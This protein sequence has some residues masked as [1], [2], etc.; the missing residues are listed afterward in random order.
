MTAALQKAVT[1]KVPVRISNIR[2]R[3]NGNFIY[4]DLSLRQA[5][6]P[7]ES[8]FP[9]LYLV[10]L[11]EVPVQI[12]SPDRDALLK[13]GP[14]K[15]DA[16]ENRRIVELEQELRAKEEYLQSTLE[17]ME[18]SSEELKSTNE[19]MQSVNEELQSSNEELETSKE[20][21]QS[22]NEELATVNSELQTKVS[23]LSRANNDMNNLLAGTG[24]ATI[25]V[26]Q[27][28]HIVRFTP[29]AI[30]LI[31]L[32]ATDIGRPVAHIVSNLA[33]YDRLAEDAQAVLNDLIPREAE[34]RTK[35]GSWFLMRIRPYRT[36]NNVIEGA[37]LTFTDIN[38][39]KQ[40]ND[41][42][43]ER[44]SQLNAILN[45]MFNAF[46][47][48]ESVSDNDGGF[49]GYRF[50]LMNDA[51]E[52]RTGIT[53]EQAY[54]KT[55]QEIYPGNETVWE[56]TLEQAAASSYPIRF[57]LNPAKVLR[58]RADEKI[59]TLGQLEPETQESGETLRIL[60]EL[61]VHRIELEM[62]NEDLRR[63]QENLEAA[64]ARYYDFY[65][66]APVGFCS[67]SEKGKI[68]E[69]NLVTA[70][71]LRSDRSMLVMKM[72]SGYILKEDQDIY[73]LLCKQLLESGEPQ[74]CELRMIKTDGAE[75]WVH[76]AAT[77]ALD[78]AGEPVSRFVLSDITDRK[79]AE[80]KIQASLAEK[81]VLLK[82]I[83]HRVKNNMQI[84][85]SLISLQADIQDDERVTRLFD[86]IRNR[87]K[88]MAMVHEKLYQT[89]DLVALDF[90]DYA[91]SLLRY[92]WDAHGAS[93]REISLKLEAAPVPFPVGTAVNCGLILNELAGNAL[94]HAFPG[95]RAGV[96][97]VT[98]A[99]DPE[100]KEVCLKVRDNGVGMPAEPDWRQSPSL[101]LR[102][103]QMLT[104]QIHGTVQTGPGPGTEFRICFSIKNSRF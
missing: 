103:V 15:T 81:D 65:N 97:T 67:I 13:K 70:E 27:Q 62:Q 91:G 74:A 23:D 7:A 28:L 82:E 22:V 5:T 52:R 101:G 96:V 44:E 2:V 10:V 87:V 3:T 50:V 46:A 12:A 85:S 9:D 59:G 99:Q 43:E 64:R 24:I 63:S 6:G 1:K 38:A 18:T 56:K 32:I 17:E 100:T 21:L 42:L 35:S 47:L 58:A 41:K 55:V 26:D 84:I 48:L 8:F 40:A 54:G 33:G 93:G 14:G 76:L 79:K 51:F 11:E 80:A 45:G 29:T 61:R 104:N 20:E 19:E 60:H 57:E 78:A 30:E 4:A 86:E 68:L 49:A 36:L 77:A 95:G 92:L 88:A 39:R 16:T 71:M 37:V 53:N 90:A 73:Y 69:T 102:L 31:N 72:F 83:H 89:K 98:L 25:F 94:K 75:F 34:V 66:L